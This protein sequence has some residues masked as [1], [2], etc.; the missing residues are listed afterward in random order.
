MNTHVD[1]LNRLVAEFDRDTEG[2]FDRLT[3]PDSIALVASL[4]PACRRGLGTE[5]ALAAGEV[6][7]GKRDRIEEDLDRAF[8]FLMSGGK[9]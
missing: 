8:N 7:A 4:W 1:R 6:K 3:D 5:L 2:R 9:P